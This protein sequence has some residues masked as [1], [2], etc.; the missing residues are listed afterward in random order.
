MNKT[1]A[2]D[3]KNGDAIFDAERGATVPEASAKIAPFA[4]DQR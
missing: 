2:A 3:A 4:E 1:N